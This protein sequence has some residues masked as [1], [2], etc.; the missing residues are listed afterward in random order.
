MNKLLTW[1]SR[2]EADPV[3]DLPAGVCRPL[4]STLPARPP[5]AL[6]AL[7]QQ[8]SM[9]R[10]ATNLLA[11]GNAL[12]AKE[13]RLKSAENH[14][15]FPLMAKQISVASRKHRSA[16]SLELA[17]P[18]PTPQKVRGAEGNSNN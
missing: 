18:S 12:P 6:L 3:F 1:N 4:A 9:P 17:Q 15:G 16:K 10:A 13:I 11:V 8:D 5:Q 14:L 2:F 7:A